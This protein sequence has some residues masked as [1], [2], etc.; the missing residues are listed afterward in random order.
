M[1]WTHSDAGSPLLTMTPISIPRSISLFAL[2]WLSRTCLSR[3]GCDTGWNAGGAIAS[4][5]VN[6]S[7]GLLPSWAMAYKQ[8]RLK[9]DYFQLSSDRSQG[10]ASAVVDVLEAPGADSKHGDG[11]RTQRSA[12]K[13]PARYGSKPVEPVDM[14]PLRVDILG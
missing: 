1:P 11:A 4:I 9:H 12:G 2:Y 14:E 5:L 7:A 6:R 8:W 10:R 13:S 3:I